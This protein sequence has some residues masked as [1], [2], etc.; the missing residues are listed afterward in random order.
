M[1]KI[2]KTTGHGLGF[3]AD[4]S[5]IIAGSEMFAKEVKLLNKTLVY[6][7]GADGGFLFNRTAANNLA[8]YMK[9]SLLDQS[10]FEGLPDIQPWWRERK[11]IAGLDS[12]IGV[13]TGSLAE[14][15]KAVGAGYAE[16]RVGVS[17]NARAD[18]SSIGSTGKIYQYAD[19]LEKGRSAGA[20]TGPQPARPWFWNT[21]ERWS[22]ENL[23][24][25]M[26]NTFGRELKN[27][28]SKMDSAAKKLGGKGS[29][30]KID[31]KDAVKKKRGR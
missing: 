31:P 3:Y 19:W 29:L 8:N 17:R 23:P 6:W 2:Q 9:Q 18:E 4:F 22:N 7:F 30:S 25:L 14:A 27:R 11:R 28:F 26:D 10:A 1:A 13:A 15:I 24:E 21:F 20:K 5:R 16:Y 12:R